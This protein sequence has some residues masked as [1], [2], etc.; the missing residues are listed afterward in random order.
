M[1]NAHLTFFLVITV[2]DKI[3]FFLAWAWFQAESI[4]RFAGPVVTREVIA[5]RG[6]SELIRAVSHSLGDAAFILGLT[7]LRPGRVAAVIAATGVP[8]VCHFLVLLA[9]S[10]LSL[11]LLGRDLLVGHRD[12]LT[13]VGTGWATLVAVVLLVRL[14]PALG[15]GFALRVRAWIERVDW[16]GLRPIILGFVALGATDVVV[17]KLTA[18]SFGI[19]LP[20]A[21]VIARLPILY[22]VLTLPS[23]GN[24]GTRE[25]AWGLLFGEFAEPTRLQA[26]ALATNAT[27][28]LLNVSI[29]MLFLPRALAL[30]DGLRAARRAGS[31]WS[32]S[33]L[34][35]PVDP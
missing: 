22:A 35:H 29:G 20:W 34:T 32:E 7:R 18:A 27:F 16:A 4:R 19:D 10:T 33:L 3:V 24:F 6:G 2:L 25:A 8:F 1:R 12:V 13:A 26:C 28:L 15:L 11:P 30:L 21:E 17:Q 14:G 9:Q 23:L 31:A 5:L